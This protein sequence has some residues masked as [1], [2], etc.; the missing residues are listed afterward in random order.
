MNIAQ[1]NVVR[2]FQRE[3]LK[4]GATAE[5]VLQAIEGHILEAAELRGVY[6]RK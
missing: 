5:E 6:S 4:Q 3:S 2:L 1:S